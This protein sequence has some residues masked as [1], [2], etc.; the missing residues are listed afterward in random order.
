MTE[1]S[2]RRGKIASSAIPLPLSL[3]RILVLI[4]RA[5]TLSIVCRVVSGILLLIMLVG[6]RISRIVIVVI[7][8]I[9]AC[10]R[11]REVST[12]WILGLGVVVCLGL[13]WEVAAGTVGTVGV[14]LVVVGVGLLI[15]IVVVGVVVVLVSI[16]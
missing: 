14:L 16:A 11:G 3:I 15:V 12:A 4:L 7:V 2:T 8:G 1:S 5:A 10:R 6:L 13:R 9:V